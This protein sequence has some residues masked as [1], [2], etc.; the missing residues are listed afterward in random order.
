M[1]D[2]LIEIGALAFI[3]VL[4]LIVLWPTDKTS[5]KVLRKWRV[6]DPTPAQ[7]AES[8]VY[9]KRRR[10]LYPWL[11][12]AISSA[13]YQTFP[14]SEDFVGTE[15][16]L[17]VLAGMLLAELVA[18]LRPSKGTRREA[19]LAPRG[20]LD[21]VPAWGLVAFGLGAVLALVMFLL[22]QPTPASGIIALVFCVVAVLGAVLLAVRRPSSG[23]GA[24]DTAF[25]VRSARVT[26]GLGVA[27]TGLLCTMVPVGGIVVPALVLGLIGLGWGLAAL[28]PRVEV[29]ARR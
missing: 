8:K 29:P 16:L 7:V 13:S 24:V 4:L 12:L 21:L 6:A 26:L 9:L 23:D 19:V 10:L 20:V 25:R 18:S 17:T 5:A 14:G 3:G 11:F 1:N 2:F 22:T 28:P 15:I 27:L